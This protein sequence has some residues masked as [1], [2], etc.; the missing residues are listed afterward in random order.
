MDPHLP[1]I[2]AQRLPVRPA[3]AH[4]SMVDADHL[5]SK[6]RQ[7]LLIDQTLLAQERITTKLVER[8]QS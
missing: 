3:P 4:R 1:E 7:R 8:N 6:H 2:L 5:V